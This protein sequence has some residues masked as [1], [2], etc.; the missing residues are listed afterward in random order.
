MEGSTIPV[1]S[2]Q[3]GTSES[4]TVHYLMTS[5]F[6]QLCRKSLTFTTNIAIS[7]NL[8]FT[9][10]SKRTYVI[11]VK[12]KIEPIED[13]PVSNKEQVTNDPEETGPIIGAHTDK[14]LHTS[15]GEQCDTDTAEGDGGRCETDLELNTHHLDTDF[16]LTESNPPFHED[17][18]MGSELNSLLDLPFSENTPML[19]ESTDSAHEPAAKLITVLHSS[20]QNSFKCVLCEKVFGTKIGL[21][22]HIERHGTSREKTF[23]CDV[24]GNLFDNAK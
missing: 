4:M 22:K 10:D 23:H 17:L 19:S 2:I 5:L 18:S 6:P 11:K 12:E 15:D 20:G 1:E 13:I 16:H 7:G 8:I 3:D 9:V 24:C 14:N 21:N